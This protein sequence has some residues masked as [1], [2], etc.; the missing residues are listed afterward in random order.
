AK[1]EITKILERDI[2]RDRGI[3]VDKNKFTSNPDEIFKDPEIDIVIELLGGIEPATTFMIS[4]MENGKHVVTANKA[5]VAA[6]YS[7]LMNT[8]KDNNVMMKFEASVGGGIPILGTLTGPLRANKFEEVMGILN[9]T[10]NYILTMMTKEGLDYN[11]ALKDAQ[12]QGFAEADP[13]A[14]VEGIDAANK[15]SI[16]MALMFD[17]YV[18]PE[19]I[20]TTG[21]TEITKEKIEEARS[22]GCKIKLIAHAQRLED[23]TID[24]E[25]R[26]MYIS[27]THPLANINKEFNAVFVK[28][29]AVDDVMF[30]GKGAGPLPTGSAVMG[31]VIEI[32][33]SILK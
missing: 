20:P 9:G 33:K 31:D 17:K 32:S 23:G 6:N 4:A 21:I 16:L 22:N 25:V 26:P 19:D 30:Y 3:T 1:V 2:D 18:A 13:T 29:N 15:L 11:T 24:Y 8:A 27:A 28:G 10:T 7:K 5:A 12:D 14:D